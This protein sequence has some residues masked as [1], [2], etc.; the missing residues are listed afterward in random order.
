MLFLKYPL[1]TA[2]KSSIS[3]DW[4]VK[5]FFIG[6]YTYSWNCLTY[7]VGASS[8]GVGKGLIVKHI[9]LIS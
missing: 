3:W 7:T 6:K 9:S 5:L 2:S 8:L 4:Y 1:R